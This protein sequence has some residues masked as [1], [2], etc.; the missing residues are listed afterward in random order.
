MYIEEVYIN[1]SLLLP[2]FQSICD[3]TN[4]VN[5]NALSKYSSYASILHLLRQCLILD[6]LFCSHSIYEIN[7]IV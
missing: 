4:I 7:L 2:P 3:I 6:G 1:V 5:D